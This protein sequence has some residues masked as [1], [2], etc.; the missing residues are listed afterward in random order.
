MIDMKRLNDEQRAVIERLRGE[1]KAD[2]RVGSHHQLNA[3]ILNVLVG[4]CASDEEFASLLH[5]SEKKLA[6]CFKAVSGSVSSG[7]S[8]FEVYTKAVQFYLP[9]VKIRMY[10]EV[11]MI[12]ESEGV[13]FSR[14]GALTTDVYGKKDLP[15]S[16]K[17]TA[18]KAKA[19]AKAD[20]IPAPVEG[21][22]DFEEN[23]GKNAQILTMPDV[24]DQQT[25]ADIGQEQAPKKRKLMRFDFFDL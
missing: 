3:P 5:S 13:A 8:D 15:K 21:E 1:Y 14:D 10:M 6:D 11:D 4:F 16:D 23:G 9:G 22:P 19:K 2:P 17:G 25:S 24:S 18:G 7:C 20:A 12:G